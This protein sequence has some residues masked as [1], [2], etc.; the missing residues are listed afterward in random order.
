LL[1]RRYDENL[2]LL[3]RLDLLLRGGDWR[4]PRESVLCESDDVTDRRRSKSGREGIVGGS[5]VRCALIVGI[6]FNY[7]VSPRRRRRARGVFVAEDGMRHRQAAMLYYNGQM[8]QSA[9]MKESLRALIRQSNFELKEGVI[10]ES[11]S[12][13]S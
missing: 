12:I 4:P 3:G 6:S 13:E 7:V 9:P 10:L 8:F 1:R 5:K 11:E 2:A